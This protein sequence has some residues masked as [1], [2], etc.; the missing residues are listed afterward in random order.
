MIQIINSKRS[1]ADVQHLLAEKFFAD[2]HIQVR[3]K[4]L[5]RTQIQN[6]YQF[7]IYD[8]LAK[9]RKDETAK[10]YR[11]YCKYHLGLDIRKANDLEFAEFIDL[12][13]PVFDYE[14]KID[15]MEYVD[16]TK[17]FSA[18]EMARYIDAILQHFPDLE[19]KINE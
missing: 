19:M 14:K 5:T 3:I 8:E 6:N 15:F 10:Y 2:K 4:A 12:I 13:L 11:N 9:Q 17:K 16:V 1:L 18:M 7:V